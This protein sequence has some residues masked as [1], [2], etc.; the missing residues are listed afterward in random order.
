[1]TR[2][3]L[4]DDGENLAVRTFLLRYAGGSCTVGQMREHLEL[5][6][7][8]GMWPEWVDEYPHDHLTKCGAQ[9]WIRHLFDLE[10]T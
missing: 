1:M 8:T 7:W 2:K 10:K 4:D 9:A 5:S 6:S 3:L